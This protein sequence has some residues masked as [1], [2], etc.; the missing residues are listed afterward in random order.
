VRFLGGA[1]TFISHGVSRSQFRICLCH[2][3]NSDLLPTFLTKVILSY[4]GALTNIAVA[5]IF[6]AAHTSSH[7]VPPGWFDALS[8]CPVDTAQ[9]EGE[10]KVR[11]S[12]SPGPWR[13]AMFLSRKIRR[14]VLHRIYKGVH[15]E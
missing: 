13:R 1:S 8:L 3:L 14:D 11:Q 7:S 15:S 6:A 5:V 12:S 10:Q 2:M 9:N 4:C